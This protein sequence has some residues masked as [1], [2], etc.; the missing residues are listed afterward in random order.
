MKNK[1]EHTILKADT[2]AQEIISLCET[3]KK[4]EFFGVCVPPY[5]VKLAKKHLLESNVK[6]VTVAGF[7]LGYN[8]TPAKVEEARK[9]LDEGADEV[10]MV[11]NIAA[12]KNG[13]FNF[14]HNDIQSVAMLVQLK[15]NKLKVIIETA[16]L[17][18]AEKL[19]ACE[20]C[21]EIGVDFVKTSTGFSSG[22][23]TVADIELLRKALPKNIK[24]KASGGI[25]TKEQAVSLVAAGADRIGTSNGPALI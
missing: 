3:A 21:S 19:K 22:G 8:T 13:D 9:A 18:K 1:I 23:A 20:I 15:G 12:L 16:L 5:F 25:K 10:D 14:V 17:S 6:I 11:L 4:H 2:T 7:P 24:I